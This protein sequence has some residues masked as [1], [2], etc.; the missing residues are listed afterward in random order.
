MDNSSFLTFLLKKLGSFLICLFIV[1]TVT[2]FLMHAIPGDPFSDEKGLSEE[3]L[4]AMETHYGLDKP[5]FI[6]YL[7]YLKGILLLDFGPSLKYPGRS[8]T[9]VIAD[10]FPVSFCLGIEALFLSIVM[11]VSFGSLAALKKGKWQDKS[12]IITSTL[13]ISIPSFLLATFL[14]YIFAMQLG[15]FPVARWGTLSQT[16]LPAFALAALPASFIA[17]LVRVTIIE[18]LYQ[19]YIQTAKAKGLSSFQILKRH[20]LRNSFLP[21]LAYLGPLTASILTGGFAV[22]KI[23]GIP[24]LGQW[25]VLSIMNRDYTVIM[26]TAIFYSSI[27]MVCVLITD[28]LSSMLDPR[29]KQKKHSDLFL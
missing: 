24:G 3:V 14:Q 19:D 15:F 22:E 2:F 26:G 13:G 11:G 9:D 27:L 18:V 1:I 6:Q 8:V 10:G 4:K 23:F 25:F 20:V 29:T 28:I 16:V 12:L 7:Q 17:R 21:I 5:L